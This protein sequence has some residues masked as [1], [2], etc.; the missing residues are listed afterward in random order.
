MNNFIKN[1]IKKHALKDFPNE[2]CGLLVLEENNN[3]KVLNCKNVSPDK[4][5]LFSLSPLDYLYASK[6]GK[7]IS[8]NHSQKSPDFSE[9]D[10][11]N[12]ENHKIKYILY[13]HDIDDFKEYEPNGYRNKYVGLNFKIGEQDCFTLLRQ[14]YLNELGIFIN[15]YDRSDGWYEKTPQIFLDNY[16]KEGFIKVDNIQI[17]D[18][19]L[20]SYCDFPTH[21]L[22]YLGN[23]Q[24]LHH[25]REKLSTIEIYT[26]SFKRRSHGIFRHKLLL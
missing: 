26:E 22:I 7:I 21:V 20:V 12:S 19:I 25:P 11:L 24:I 13:S 2:A 4:E 10:K 3:I 23:N 1:Q 15:N 6:I 8:C 14:Y 18:V 5:K 16:E 17:N 9:Y